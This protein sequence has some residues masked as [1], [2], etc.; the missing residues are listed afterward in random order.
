MQWEKR[1]VILYGLHSLPK[2]EHQAL[3]QWLLYSNYD[4]ATEKYSYF[5]QN[6]PAFL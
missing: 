5:D 6:S 2:S 1:G 3:M 4:I